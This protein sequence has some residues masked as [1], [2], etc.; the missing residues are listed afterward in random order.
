[1]VLDRSL[2]CHPDPA[3]VV[4]NPVQEKKID[5]KIILF[6]VNQLI[7]THNMRIHKLSLWNMHA[8]KY[9]VRTATKHIFS[10][11]SIY[12]EFIY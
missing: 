10:I 5:K 4:V 8:Q 9:E 6:L 7:K 2:R 12:L 11:F 3:A 1:M